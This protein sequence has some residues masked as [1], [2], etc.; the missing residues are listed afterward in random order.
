MIGAEVRR[1]GGGDDYNTRGN[2]RTRT[3]TDKQTGRAHRFVNRQ[4]NRQIK[5]Q[6]TMQRNNHQNPSQ[7]GYQT[8]C[9]QLVY[10]YSD[11]LQTPST[12]RHNARTHPDCPYS[13]P[14]PTHLSAPIFSLRVVADIELVEV[15]VPSLRLYVRHSCW[16]FLSE[17]RSW[18]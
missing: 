8:K 16:I 17:K 4:K 7:R 12:H 5:R 11:F 1:H 6:L 14:L 3:A 13:S 18:T 2:G 9:V 10:T 15:Q